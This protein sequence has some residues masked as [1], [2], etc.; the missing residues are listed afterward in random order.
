MICELFDCALW[1][2]CQDLL[3]GFATYF[4]LQKKGSEKEFISATPVS[5]NFQTIT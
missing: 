5:S 3:S 1:L 2:L 4:D